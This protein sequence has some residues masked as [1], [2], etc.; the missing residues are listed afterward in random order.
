MI[1]VFYALFWVSVEF[2]NKLDPVLRLVLERNNN[3]IEQHF[4][5]HN[6]DQ[7]ERT[8]GVACTSLQPVF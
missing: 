5:F 1:S 2:F 6:E 4:N 8:E 7:L 3:M